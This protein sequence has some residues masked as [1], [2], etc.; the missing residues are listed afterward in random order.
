MTHSEQGINEFS[1]IEQDA[2]RMGVGQVPPVTRVSAARGTPGSHRVVSGIRFG[3]EHPLATFLHGAGLNAHTFD[4]TILAMGRPALSLDLP[5]HGDSTWRDDADYR[6]ETIARDLAP[7]VPEFAGDTPQVVIG[8]SLGGLAAAV[9]AAERPALV[10]ALVI[11]DITPGVTPETGS[12]AVREF[13]SG[14]ESFASR[15]AIVD[16]AIAFGIGHDRDVLARGVFLNTRER[17]DGRFE[18]KHHLARLAAQGGS[19]GGASG[20]GRSPASQAFTSSHNH[21]WDALE[22]LTIPVTLIRASAGFVSEENLRE[23]RSR[24]PGSPVVE[25]AA[26]HNV[27]EHAP[28][29]LADALRVLVDG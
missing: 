8:Q 20:P 19:V 7:V 24:M 18:F 22:K 10:R 29:E 28:R 16:R 13:I 27:Q 9:L 12:D 17:A 11:I 15:E 25:I 1:F 2:A 23:W 4:P 3:H 21:V 26:G 6:P 14:E 5:G